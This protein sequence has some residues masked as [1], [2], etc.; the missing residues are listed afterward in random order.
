MARP[1]AYVTDE[2]IR[3]ARDLF[4]ERG[5]EATSLADLEERTGLNRSSLY[6][7][8]G[9]KRGLFEEALRHYLREEAEPRLAG[10]DRP[11]AGLAEVTGYLRGLAASL[12][13]H[14]A[15][16]RRGCLM[17]NTVAELADRDEGARQVGLA[18]R[19][20]I[21]DALGGAL[22]NAAHRGLLPG[23]SVAPR[24]K[25]LTA[26]VLGVLLDAR[27]DPAEAADVADATADEVDRW[28]G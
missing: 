26:A 21:A 23:D 7:A 15:A 12:R 13:A 2:V 27:I 18:Y 8:F 1:R 14:P 17:V 6:Q 5:Y 28:A 4:W 22:R 16:A 25:L 20:R 3:A 19:E 24:V 11:G 10:L 9:S